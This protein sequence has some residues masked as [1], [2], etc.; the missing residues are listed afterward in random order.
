MAVMSAWALAPNECVAQ[1]RTTSR[2]PARASARTVARAAATGLDL[3]GAPL[4]SSVRLQPA[5]TPDPTPLTVTA[6]GAVAP[7]NCPGFF[8]ARPQA[9]LDVTGGFAWLRVYV[10]GMDDTTLMVRAPDGTW[11]CADDTYGY[12][13]AIDGTFT[14]GAYR[15]WVGT[16]R[17]GA[18]ASGSLTFTTR[19]QI[20]PPSPAPTQPDGPQNPAGTLQQAVNG[21]AGALTGATQ[22]GSAQPGG[23]NVPVSELQQAGLNPAQLP[24]ALGQ[25]LQS[26]ATR[27]VPLSPMQLAQLA[28]LA[29]QGVNAQQLQSIA[30]AMSRSSGGIQQGALSPEQLGQVTQM[31]SQG[32]T[33][34]A[35]TSAVTNMLRGAR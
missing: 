22:G 13:P 32:A 25:V 10:D 2:A 7:G 23:F 15:V 3:Q 34:A 20:V 1:T 16:P 26:P 19:R 27:G 30:T 8:S 11:R 17:T 14:P 33:A 6:G 35:L 4:G 24:A 29:N 21:V 12:N 28:Q 18:Q 5:F 31:A 9:V